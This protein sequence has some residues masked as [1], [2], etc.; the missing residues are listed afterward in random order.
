V[1]YQR[2][3]DV[4]LVLLGGNVQGGVSILTQHIIT[5]TSNIWSIAQCL[6]QAVQR[7]LNHTSKIYTNNVD[8]ADTKM[9]KNAADTH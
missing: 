4:H 6:M 5:Y 7:L 1:L 9:P 3:D 2:T 8:V